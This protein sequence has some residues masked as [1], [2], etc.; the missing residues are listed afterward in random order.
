MSNETIFLWLMIGV[1]V[2][3]AIVLGAMEK[4]K[5]E[6]KIKKIVN[7]LQQDEEQRLSQLVEDER[8][9]AELKGEVE[10]MRQRVQ[11]LEKIATD[12][13]V[14]LADEIEALRDRKEVR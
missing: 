12:K 3:L 7:G 1:P 10:K 2:I 9:K 8:K 6:T 5:E 13:G 14:M 4:R 11:H